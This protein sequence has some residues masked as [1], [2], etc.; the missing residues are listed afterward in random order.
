MK[1]LEESNER[2]I[3]EKSDS[4]WYFNHL[5]RYTFAKPMVVSKAVLD[6]RCGEGYGASILAEVAQNVTAIDIDE[7]TIMRAQLKYTSPNLTYAKMDASSLEFAEASFD[8]VCSFEVFEHIDDCHKYLSE[9]HRVLKTGGLF[10]VSTPNKDKYPRAG[11]NPFHVRE[12]TLDEFRH[13]LAEVFEEV[14]IYGQCCKLKARQLYHTP[15]ARL[16]YKIRRC[17]GIKLRI[18]TGL[19]HFAEN[20]FTG[21][22]IQEVKIDD[23]DIS[24]DQV[25]EA[26]EFVALCKRTQ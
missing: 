20:V 2:C 25:E 11:L 23:F 17:L 18:P 3:P 22:S 24:R 8:V 1:R 21:H 15:L 6:A 10:I 9:I 13:Q 19:R 5:A 16:I 12:F 14:E 7:H 4:Y 26:E